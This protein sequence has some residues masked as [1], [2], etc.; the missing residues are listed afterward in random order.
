M[1][2]ISCPS[3]STKFKIPPDKIGLG[4]NMTCAKCQHKWFFQL[5]E[6]TPSPSVEEISAAIEKMAA[7][8]STTAPQPDPP[9]MDAINTLAAHAQSGHAVESARRAPS[10]LR[11]WLLLVA[12]IGA[13]LGLG[14]FAKNSIIAAWPPVVRIYELAGMHIPTLGEGLEIRD[15]AWEILREETIDDH[16]GDKILKKPTVM[17]IKG[18]I[19]NRAA[20]PVMIPPVFAKIIGT[21]QKVLHTEKFA[22]DGEK[23]LPTEAI[24]FSTKIPI[25]ENTDFQVMV[26]FAGRDVKD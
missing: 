9:P 8:L 10:T 26:T 22:A 2:I 7:E 6:S 17:I 14:V 4:K 15:L 3:C 19:V 18:A 12:L 5:P 24:P 16:T 25:F 23:I 13:I 11:A 1:I 21:D 20:E